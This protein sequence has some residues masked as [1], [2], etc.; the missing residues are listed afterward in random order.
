MNVRPPGE[1]LYKAAGHVTSLFLLSILKA[2]DEDATFRDIANIMIRE[3]PQRLFKSFL[4]MEFGRREIFDPS[5]KPRLRSRGFLAPSCHGI[6]CG[7][8]D[9]CKNIAQ[10]QN[11]VRLRGDSNSG[12]NQIN[13]V[14][15]RNSPRLSAPEGSLGDLLTNLEEFEEEPIRRMSKPPTNSEPYIPMDTVH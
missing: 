12:K 11:G 9:A 14:I 15:G 5:A 8:I 2:P 7:T 6:S 10:P 1:T 13:S 3:E 4:Q